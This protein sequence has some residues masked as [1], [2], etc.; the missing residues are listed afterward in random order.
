MTKEKTWCVYVHISPSIKYYVGI[1]SQRLERRWRK[2]VGYLHNK[3]FTRTIN[4]YGW[5]NF[6][7]EVIASNLTEEEARNFEQI[8]ISKLQSNNPQYGYNITSGGECELHSE[9]TKQLL[10]EIKG[11]PVC[12]FDLDMN[13]IKEYPSAKFASDSTGIWASMILGCCHNQIG[14]KTAGGYIWIFKSNL[15]NVDFNEYKKRLKHE[16]MPKPVCQFSLSMEFIA[17]YESIGQASR[18]TG[19]PGP[20]ISN[21]LSGKS[22][23][24]HG[25]IWV[26]KE[27]LKKISFEE[28][29]RLKAYKKPCC[30][31]IYQFSKNMEF[32][33]EFESRVEAGKSIGVTPQAIGYAC[34][35]KTH[36]SHGYLRWFKDDYEREV[37]V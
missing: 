9:E 10:R 26:L 24:T 28:I 15:P 2:G 8:L 6:Q 12:Q 25:F 35:S 4:K 33:Q 18:I 20:D 5:D 16:K 32:I 31:P 29:K 37:V 30:R 36:E 1:T 27:D 19:I 14:Y 7:H 11:T 34:N 3:Y 13:F 21:A 23:Q 22:K 17:E